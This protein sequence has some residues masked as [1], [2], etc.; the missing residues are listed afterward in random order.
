M[1]ANIVCAYSL[2]RIEEPQRKADSICGGADL[3]LTR[4]DGV[5]YEIAL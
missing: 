4:I 2:R 5:V 3:H 1:D